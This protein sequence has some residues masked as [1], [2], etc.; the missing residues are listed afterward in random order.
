MRK[1]KS[2]AAIPL[3]PIFSAQNGPTVQSNKKWPE[4]PDCKKFDL[5]DVVLKGKILRDF[6]P[7]VFSK[8]TSP[9]PLFRIIT[10]FHM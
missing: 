7:L 6:Q 1:T 4:P 8:N 3:K 2:R 5:V 9:L 10:H